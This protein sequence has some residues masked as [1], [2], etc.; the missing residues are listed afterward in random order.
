MAVFDDCLVVLEVKDLPFKEKKKLKLAITDNGGTISFVVNNQC[1][2]VVTN[3]LDNVSSNRQH[4]IKKFQIPVVGVEY[5]FRCV[6]K[7]TLLSTEE[8]SP[9]PLPPTT[10]PP[11]FS[12]TVFKV[13]AQLPVE[14]KPRVK[15]T[16][17]ALAPRTEK[18]EKETETKSGSYLGHHRVYSEY[19]NDLPKFPSNFKVAK[20]SIL[21]R[22]KPGEGWTVLELQSCQSQ[23]GQQYRVV[24]YWS[25]GH[26][27]RVSVTRD[28]LV[29]CSTSEE[30]LE[31][32]ETL[33]KEL[34]VMNV[35]ESTTLPSQPPDVGSS[36]LRQL[37]LEEKLNSSAIS[38][39][40]GVFVELLWTEAL[41]CLGN[42]L[43]IP[44]TGISLNDVC[45][46]EGLL[47]QVQK[48]LKEGAKQEELQRL[49]GEFYS[50]LP[51]KLE[52]TPTT[53]IISQKLDLCQLIRDMLKVSEATMWS[54]TPSCLGKYHALRCSIEHLSPDSPDYRNV[55]SLL[56]GRP[57]QILQ[58]FRVSRTEELQV[59]RGEQGNV[60]P[61]LHSTAPSS[62]VGIL[63]RGLLLPRVGVEHHGIERTDIGN[64]GGGIYFSDSLSTSMKYSKPGATDGSR[65]LLVCDVAL[66]Q[67]KDLQKR[68]TSLSCAP[69]GYHSV[70]G[71]R[72]SPTV[73]S[74][75]EDDEYVVYSTDQVQVKYVVQFRAR[76]DPVTAF[77]PTVD[78]SSDTAQPASTADLLSEEEEVG[79]GGYKNPLEDVTA[80]LLDSTGQ[81][82]PLQ[83]VSVKCK[84]MDLLTQVI[85]FQTYT[86]LSKVPIEAKYVFPLDE[87]AAVCGFEAFINGKHIVGQVKE[88]EQAR[89]EYRQAI[90]KGHG[91]YLMDQDAPDV[92]T[93]S[94]GNLPA[95]ATVLIKVTYVTELV[96]KAGSLLFSLPGSVA[97]WQQ[98]KALNQRTQ[99]S[100]E[101]VCVN[102]LQEEGVF[103]LDMSIE[104]PYEILNLHCVTHQVKIKKTECKAVVSTLPGQTL[105]P[106][107]FQ[108]SFTLSQVHLPRMWVENHPDKDSQAC[109]LVFYPH[110]D[111]NCAAGSGD[112]DGDK[113]GGEEVVI[114]LDTSESM[115]GIPM[116]DAR[117]IAL[118]VLKT[119]DPKVRVNI[120]SFGTDYKELFLFSQPFS[121]AHQPAT[122]FAMTSPPMGGSTDLW[123]PLHSLSLL[124]PS[125]TIRNLL[126]ISDG[127]IQS[128]A[129]TLRLIREN[130]Q[131]S[132]VFTC[133]ISPT[134]NR[135]MLRALAQAGGGAYEFFDTKMKHTWMGKV[136]SQVKRMSAPGCSSV[137]VK[138]QQ[139]NLGASPPVQAPAQL[140][141]LFS[142]CHALVYGFVP[143][144]TQ[145]T[146][147]GRLSEQ[148]IETMVSTTEL[149][150]SKGTLLHKLT[151]RAVIRDYEDGSLH[152]DQAEHEGR[153]EELKSYIIELSKEYSIVT[154][155]TSFVAIEERDADGPSAGFTDIPKLIAEEE[156]D[157]LPYIGWEEDEDTEEELCSFYG[158]GEK[159]PCLGSSVPFDDDIYE[160]LESDLMQNLWEKGD[161]MEAPPEPPRV[162]DGSL[163]L[164]K[165]SSVD[166]VEAL[167]RSLAQDSLETLC[168]D[169][170]QFLQ[171]D[172]GSADEPVMKR[173]QLKTKRMGPTVR[174]SAAPPAICWGSPSVAQTAKAAFVACSPVPPFQKLTFMQAQ[175]Q[176]Q[177]MQQFPASP[178]P[179]PPPSHPAAV[180]PPPPP[181]FHPAAVP[182]PPP[183]PSH[184]AA[185]P[186]PPPPPFHPAAAPPPPPPPFHPA[187]VPP[188]PP[189]P[190]HP[191]AVPPPPPPPFHPA[192]VPPP[193][194]PPFHPAAVPPPPP[195]PSHP[196]AGLAPPPPPFHPIGT[197]LPPASSRV[198]ATMAAPSV[199]ASGLQILPSLQHQ[200]TLF[201]SGRSR[202]SS[203]AP[204]PRK[205]LP[206]IGT[207]AAD[208]KLTQ[209]TQAGGF[210]AAVGFGSSPGASQPAPYL[211][212]KF[213]TH[214][215]AP[216]QPLFG[217]AVPHTINPFQFGSVS[218]TP[219]THSGFQFGAKAGDAVTPSPRKILPIIGT[220]AANHKLSQDTQAGGFG[221]AV[222][223]G[224]SPG[225]SPPAPYL[226]TKFITHALAPSQ[227]LF[228]AA[229]PHTVTPFQF[230]SVSGTP[231]TH[232]GFQFGAK[233]GDAVT[234]SVPLF[235][236]AAG[237]AITPSLPD[238]LTRSEL[239]YSSSSSENEKREKAQM[240]IDR[241]RGHG[242]D[243][244]TGLRERKKSRGLSWGELFDLQHQDGYWEC[245][246]RLGSILGL[247]IEFFANVF[248]KEK[249]IISLGVRAHADIL[250]LVATLLVLQLMRVMGLAEGSLLKTLF[251]LQEA[252][253]LK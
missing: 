245:T 138:W 236:A 34:N 172:A 9:L 53:R 248:L 22:M 4:S 131:H 2:H 106:D 91:A 46:A 197:P 112:G 3:S 126:L 209:D 228:G 68:D 96:V 205:S 241:G 64:L 187:A 184:P 81:P 227:P 41:G 52:S 195:P 43:N 117:R 194:P 51:H 47:L 171:A 37:L 139:F 168:L 122:S 164:N 42:I 107:G 176:E 82:L 145:A 133:G 181:P 127:H 60:R 249:G 19:D 98:S 39:E 63:S 220:A 214:A 79:A 158:L 59:F 104:M 7:G 192:A 215:L 222:G 118:H 208:D 203:Y 142:D 199:L 72:Q 80:G 86:N 140:H 14:E 11:P 134:A 25:K 105:G 137:S 85:I 242:M 76:D 219:I 38:Q 120:I 83:A 204:S 147:C 71:V 201:G 1:T 95:G 167:Q 250:R 178:P 202:T 170:E 206:I 101:K 21:R 110:F 5:V 223:L 188:P 87:S 200:N 132:R 89:K 57:V 69:E 217:A 174:R 144:C 251:R 121:K 108:L 141:A 44:I 50:L 30:A 162:P 130:A 70:H 75:F 13:T 179:P 113:D 94:V 177:K 239:S 125:R 17:L 143:H 28:K 211:R 16:P 74:D 160:E 29:Y 216:S 225:A 123:R 150:K 234:S 163:K 226:R 166:S 146:L 237:S 8:C 36:K 154:Q 238:V 185:A 232:S 252:P 23:A 67:C 114:L 66:G 88:K 218:G 109:M 54:S 189:P 15:Y 151:A 152:A 73:P 6:E 182:P 213:I 116:Q 247:D 77:Q 102:E 32:Y 156:V 148:E 173:A 90:E 157:F 103:T 65:L 18:V 84:L 243:Q 212:T 40:V 136:L 207:A 253:A 12:Q 111:A 58:V 159:A 119:L 31:V 233:A 196:A 210:G 100:V 169:S 244:L 33:R 115:R 161:Q 191:A 175:H 230:Q 27:C 45:R 190:S 124:P 135:H 24:R 229:V 183:P 193:P 149:Q 186:P 97:P 99:V 231:I 61:L 128:E 55:R 49:M 155:Y 78:V 56:H 165:A 246:G 129:L 93:I 153:K 35:K 198:A 240:R 62:F 48:G 221:A 10:N 20:Y 26:G 224:S 180:P 235:E 92:F